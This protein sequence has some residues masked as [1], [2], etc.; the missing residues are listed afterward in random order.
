[1]PSHQFVCR[2]L[3]LLVAVA[4]Q[5]AFH[6]VARAAQAKPLGKVTIAAGE[7]A[8]QNTPAGFTLPAALAGKALALRGPGGPLPVVVDGAGHATVIIPRLA[9]GATQAF[10]LIEMTSPKPPKLGVVVAP[11]PGGLVLSIDG[12]PVLHYRA[13]GATPR[14]DIK[15]EFVRGGYLHPVLTPQ[16]VTV[17]DDYPA[18]HKHHHGIWTAWTTTEYEGRK[19]DFWNMGKKGARKDHV[20]LGATFSGASAGGFA[21]KLSSTDLGA[22]PPKVVL[23]EDWQV[24]AYRTHA[25]APPYYLFDLVWKDTL[26]GTSPLVLPEYRYGGLG[27]RG[28]IA[29]LDKNAVTFLTSEGK[30]RIAGDASKARWCFMGGKVEGKPAGITVIDHPA[31]FRYPE[32]LRIHPD[33]P[34]LSVSPPKEGKFAI[35]P[36]KPYVA[37][38]R[39]VVSDGS[40]D[41]ALLDRLADDF[42]K[43]P[44][45]TVELAR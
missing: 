3:A 24:T 10:D 19:P 28:N 36:G 15:P 22:T 4:A 44:E 8:R 41:K 29:W 7:L 42:A 11:E 31:N 30:D 45:V 23:H 38:Y 16:G 34:Y 12:K 39:F 20:A 21:A 25:K 35:E 5:A 13:E 40:A 43:P 6:P 2:S 26:V 37:R 18:D 33:E 17:T 14:A 9:K 27:V 1:M 32:P